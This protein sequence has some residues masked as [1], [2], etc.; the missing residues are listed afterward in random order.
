MA[1]RPSESN[2]RQITTFFWCLPAELTIDFQQMENLFWVLLDPWMLLLQLA[3]LVE[4]D[5][6]ET[7]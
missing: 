3:A 1:L 6:V 2:F 4:F 7:N 5:S